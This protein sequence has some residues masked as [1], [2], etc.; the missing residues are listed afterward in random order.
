MNIF[1]VWFV[2]ITGFIVS[3]F[4]KPKKVY[5]VSKK[6]KKRY[7]KGA[8][9]VIANHFSVMDVP[10]IMFFYFFNNFYFWASEIMF[11]QKKLNIWFLKRMGAIKVDRNIYDFS[12]LIPSQKLLKKQKKIIIFPESRIHTIKDPMIN[13]FKPSY[14]YLALE[15]NVNIIP[16]Y[17]QPN[18][19]SKHK[20]YIMVGEEININDY[21]N[22]SI[23]EFNAMV[24]DI[25][26]KLGEKLIAKQREKN[27]KI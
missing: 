15:E 13:E 12:F 27:I 10:F 26:I 8:K 9:I 18:F 4:Y 24:Q 5:Y 16:L 1:L 25:I 7:L 14:A 19:K 20:G 3:L 23:N 2:K 6:A 17:I 21:A 11:K 22:L